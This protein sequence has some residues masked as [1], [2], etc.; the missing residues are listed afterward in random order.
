VTTSA[1]FS[2][3]CLHSAVLLSWRL[4]SRTVRRI[5]HQPTGF[6]GPGV[7]EVRNRPTNS[8]H[9]ADGGCLTTPTE[10]AGWPRGS[11][12]NPASEYDSP[13][14]RRKC[15]LWPARDPGRPIAAA[16]AASSTPPSRQQRHRRRAGF[17]H[18]RG[19]VNHRTS[20]RNPR[21]TD[22]LSED[23]TVR[24]RHNQ[25]ANSVGVVRG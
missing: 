1:R 20:A 17:G 13:R 16:F 23:P 5:G 15:H 7:R 22:Q 11:A 19:E 8:S 24:P 6:G 18:R 21:P 12:C 10:H 3:W 2:G 14:A 9:L 4:R 25:P